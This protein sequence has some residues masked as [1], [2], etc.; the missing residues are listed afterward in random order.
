MTFA[1]VAEELNRRG[2]T[3]QSG[4]VFTGQNVQM[5]LRRNK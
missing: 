1:K 4:G 3:T 5:V 2:M